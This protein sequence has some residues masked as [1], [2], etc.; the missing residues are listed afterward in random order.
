MSNIPISSIVNVTS[1]I[2]A[3]S[4]ARGNFSTLNIITGETGVLSTSDRYRLYSTIDAVADDW[5][6]TTEAYKAAN[7]YFSQSP[8]PNALMISFRNAATETITESLNAIEDIYSSWYGFV[9]T[10]EVRDGVIIN[11]A[12]DTGPIEAA[13]WAQS[14]SKV[15]GNVTNDA[16]ALLITSTTDVGATLEAG[17][18][19]RTFTDYSSLAS[20]YPAASGFGRAFTVNFSQPDSTITLKFKQKPTI[21]PEANLTSTQ[22]NVL[23]GKRINAYYNVGNGTN[24]SPIYAE[25]VM[26]AELYF[27]DRH[28]IDWLIDA[29]QNQV[30]N[31][32]RS[33]TTKVPLTNRG[34]AQLEQQVI[35]VLDEAVNNGML[36][37][38]YTSD[39]VFLPRGYTTSVQAVE[40][41]ADADKQARKGPAI[42][43]TALLAGAVHS[44]EI[45]VNFER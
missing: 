4:V 43:V 23:Q 6:D 24:G 15:F 44:V 30:Y 14:R 41:I 38:G 31:Y 36:A 45:N 39:D 9:F 21:T 26:A 42:T 19:T 1:S 8:Q 7:T 10:N 27:D 20:E 33:S 32:L 16:D 35:T 29:I 2:G 13:K 22:L 17:G 11:G 40:D 3:L 37:P 12:A 18:Y 25:G 5:A 34:G 28:N